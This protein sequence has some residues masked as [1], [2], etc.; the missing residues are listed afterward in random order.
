MKVEKA[1]TRK[2]TGIKSDIEGIE[3]LCERERWT[4]RMKALDDCESITT[5]SEYALDLSG[6]KSKS[7]CNGT[8]NKNEGHTYLDQSN[9]IRWEGEFVRQ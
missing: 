5:K 4:K 6:L 7:I 3:E 2:Y 9:I 1:S 8:N